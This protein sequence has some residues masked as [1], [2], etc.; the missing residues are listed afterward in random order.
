[1]I[2]FEGEVFADSTRPAM[3]MV[4]EKLVRMWMWSSV[5]LIR[6][7]SQSISCRMVAM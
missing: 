2:H 4:R 3:V 5:P 1:M 6:M 7:G